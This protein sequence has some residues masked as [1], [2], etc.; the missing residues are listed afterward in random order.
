MPV[1]KVYRHGVTAACVPTH[2]PTPPERTKCS[3]WTVS[4][5]RR[6]RQFL[7]SVDERR[8]TGVGF[9][10]TLT[11]KTCPP[12]H[13]DWGAMRRAYFE[14]LR[15]LG[16]I[17]AHWLTEWQ[18]RGVP[19][20]HTAVWFP[21][22]VI[23]QYASP[24]AFGRVLVLHW[25]QLAGDAYNALPGAQHVTPIWDV[26]GWNQYVSKHAARGLNH[27]QRNP[28]NIPEGWREIGTG[29]MWG[30]LATKAEP[31]PLV[32]ATAV[33]LPMLAFWALRRIVRGYRLADARA[34][35]V[36][37]RKATAEARDPTQDRQARNQSRTARRR[38]SSAR[39]MLKAHDPKL[40]AVRG[41]SEWLPQGD[42]MRVLALFSDQGHEITS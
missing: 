32:E 16:M 17:R 21:Q 6:N 27:Y 13:E 2:V 34:A 4:A 25:C 30:Y 35:L 15:R 1:M 41:V 20:L 29:R 38:I 7:Y 36:K 31:W 39:G 23:D 28:A 19:H 10:I 22:E 26:V 18:R 33:D 40:S 5:I 37:A 3:G 14:R 9:A 42:Q 12:T 11:V 8:L 24:E